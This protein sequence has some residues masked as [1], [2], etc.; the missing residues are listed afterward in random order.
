MHMTE[1]TRILSAVE[2]GDPRAAAQLL[3]LVYDQ[4]R[5]LAAAKLA[6]EKPGH[7]LDATAL[8]HEAFLRLGCGSVRRGTE[9]GSKSRATGRRDQRSAQLPQSARNAATSSPV[10]SIEVFA[11]FMSE[12]RSLST[13]CGRPKAWP[14]SCATVTARP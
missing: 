12:A 1:I 14:S 5:Q 10:G 7:T 2:A 13:T 11:G 6:H 3:P 4:L 8:V 9:L